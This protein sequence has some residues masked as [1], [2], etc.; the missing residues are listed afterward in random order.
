MTDRIEI[1]GLK[2]ARELHDFMA[3]EALPGTGIGNPAFWAAF[4]SV[5]VFRR[6]RISSSAMPSSAP[7]ASS[8]RSRPKIACT[9]SLRPAMFHC[10]A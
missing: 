1:A 7:H 4:S 3:N 5:A 2:I 10:S 6:S 9:A 8:G